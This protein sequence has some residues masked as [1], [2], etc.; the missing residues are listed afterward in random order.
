MVGGVADKVNVGSPK[1][2]PTYKTSEVKDKESV[3]GM[4]QPRFIIR[5]DDISPF[6][7][8][9]KFR[10]MV[11]LFVKYDAPALLG[12]IPDNRDDDIR[13]ASQPETEFVEELRELDKA[14]W[15]IAQHGYRHIKHTTSGGI[16]DINQASE[17]AERDYDDQVTDLRGGR[18]ILRSYG[19]HPVTFIPP[20]HS[21]DESTLRA[22][23]AVGF[24]A[25]SDGWF[26][27]PRKTDSLLQLPVFLW[28]APRRMKM[29]RRLGAVYTICL[30]PHLVTDHE[31][32][33]LE[34]FLR[35]ETPMLTT[36]AKLLDESAELT[37]KSMKKYLLEK[38]FEAYY[39]HQG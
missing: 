9:D 10:A 7:D 38:L 14:G 29:L 12:V 8:R 5:W 26:L 31:M 3:A 32:K 25:L 17:F 21:Y 18:D 28:S 15:E 4:A 34:K 22:L 13:F 2:L 20:W 39:R 16:W 36:P 30:H 37:R 11:D 19:L 1:R 23:A 24:R 33:L 35:D 27:Y 6:H